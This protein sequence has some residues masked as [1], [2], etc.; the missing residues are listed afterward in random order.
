[1]NAAD[2]EKRVV[3]ILSKTHYHR[4]YPWERLVSILGD[5]NRPMN[6]RAKRFILEPDGGRW[7]VTYMNTQQFFYLDELIE[8]TEHWRDL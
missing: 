5:P 2:I 8:G 7:R 4:T 6:D 1:M 3:E